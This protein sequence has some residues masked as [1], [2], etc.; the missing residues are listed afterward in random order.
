[1][2]ECVD[3]KKSALADGE[4]EQGRLYAICIPH[5]LSALLVV[6][7]C[8]STTVNVRAGKAH[9]LADCDLAPSPQQTSNAHVDS[10]KH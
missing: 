10:P 9:K 7:A 5:S 4:T 1:M 2:T 3:R 8:S 6:L